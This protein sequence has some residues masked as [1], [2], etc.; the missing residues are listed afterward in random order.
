MIDVLKRFLSQFRAEGQEA[1]T[2]P[3][4]VSVIFRLTY[5]DLAIGNLTLER[6]EWEFA[7]TPEFQ[8]QSSVQP[9]VGFPDVNKRYRSET[10]W[11]FFMTRIPSADQP[12]VQA[13]VK[14]EGLDVS[15]D[16]QLLKRFGTRTISNP[17]ILVETGAA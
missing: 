6:G 12:Q 8:A 13:A 16:V 3:K 14:G 1:V 10:L 11:P 7:Y 17:F 15:S 5:Q 2:T 4:D 9:L